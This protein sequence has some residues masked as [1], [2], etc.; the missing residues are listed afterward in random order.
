MLMIPIDLP[1][2]LKYLNSILDITNRKKFDRKSIFLNNLFD[3]KS[4]I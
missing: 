4:L 2:T 3:H 1:K